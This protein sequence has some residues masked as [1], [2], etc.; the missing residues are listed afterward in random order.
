MAVTSADGWVTMNGTV[1]HNYQR[2]VAKHVIRHLRGLQGFT[3]S[4]KVV[5]QQPKDLAERVSGSLARNGALDAE[6]IK[7]TDWTE[8]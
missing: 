8:Q 4:V 3:N 5:K 6:H 2:L 7:V 1:R